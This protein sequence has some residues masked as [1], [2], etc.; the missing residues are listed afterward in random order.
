MLRYSFAMGKEADLLE[1]AV[2]NVLA[3]GFRTGD[4]MQ[5]G[6]KPVSTTEMGEAV[7]DALSQHAGEYGLAA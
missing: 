2:S 5:P 4:I 1:H 6:C 7:L 3:E